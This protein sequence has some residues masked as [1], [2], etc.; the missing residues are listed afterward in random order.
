[1]KRFVFLLLALS[2][3]TFAQSG[4]VIQGFKVDANLQQF[5]SPGATITIDGTQSFGPTVNPIRRW[6]RPDRTL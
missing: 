3:T 2:I 5:N 6:S 4:G 1:M